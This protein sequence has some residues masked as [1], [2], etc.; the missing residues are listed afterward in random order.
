MY[1]IKNQEKFEFDKRF[2]IHNVR[3]TNIG[4]FTSWN[5]SSQLD[6]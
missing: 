5:L 1:E 6:I 3:R 2:S 4:L